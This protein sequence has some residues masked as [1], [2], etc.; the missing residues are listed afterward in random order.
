MNLQ[1]FL[2]LLIF[3]IVIFGSG[4]VF[5]RRILNENKLIYLIPLSICFGTSLFIIVLHLLSLILGVRTATN[6]SLLLF[7]FS[8]LAMFILFKPSNSIEYGISKLQFIVLCVFSS[9][10]SLLLFWYLVVFNSFDSLSHLV[11]ILSKQN[12]Y[13]S[14][15]HMCPS[16]PMAY[17][18]GV[19]LLG[20]A[21]AIFSGI[22]TW[23]SLIPIQV[24]FAF[25]VPMA[26]FASFYSLTKSFLQTMLGVLIGCF[27]ANLISLTLFTL[28]NSD[29]FNAFIHNPYRVFITM[30][31]SGFA[32]STSK[33]LVTSNM[34]VAIPF[35]LLLFFLSTNERA[36][37]KRYWFVIFIISAYLFFT[38]ESFW[39]PVLAGII[40]F[41]VIQLIQNKATLNQLKS[42]IILILFLV[43]SPLVVGGIFS[44]T[45]ITKL[46]YFD[47][48]PYTSSWSGLLLFLYPSDSNW[49]KSHEIISHTDGLR[50]YKVFFLSKYFF[51]EMG[52]P[53][54][55]LPIIFAWL[56][57]KKNTV[58]LSF[59]FS[60]IVALIIPFLI[61]YLPRP[62]EPIRF[63]TYARLV[64]S[65]LLGLFF[66]ALIQLKLQ[67][68]LSFI[69]RILLLILVFTL[70]IPP[71]TWFI[72]LKY[73]EHDYRINQVS[74]IDK[75]ALRW[76]NKHMKAGD[77]GLGP[78]NNAILFDLINLAGV[79]GVGVSPVPLFQET[80]RYT[81]FKTLDPCLLNELR[82]R[83]I[84]LNNQLL[85]LIPQE[86]LNRLTDEKVLFL[87]YQSR[88]RD[89]I[90]KIYQFK[91]INI[92]EY[93]KSKN[94]SWAIGRMYDG[95][96]IPVINASSK[97][98]I[99]FTNKES[100]L[101]FL[102]EIKKHFD[103]KEAYW[104]RTEA[105]T[106]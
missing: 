42:S 9:F 8:S 53:L 58:L 51:L 78:F 39:A 50:F 21:L 76:L 37:K 72:P 5:S 25:I 96:F 98:Q 41:Q 99:H 40:I 12:T 59:L 65:I 81:A 27:C 79:Y 7:V 83:W 43:I 15:S 77:I 20:S 67:T 92:E 95:K 63:F 68:Y 74:S 38:Y 86:T 101:R 85:S 97:S 91:P 100:A 49:Y 14:L 1:T 18:C 4:Y 60:G 22:E 104:Y 31:E 2:L 45:N 52:L 93:C 23:S 44:D 87:Q 106:N 16:A 30:S 19:I 46:V 105:I 11:T 82:V 90:R 75:K 48:K 89:N 71:I 24:I 69:I 33:A 26:I 64:F 54:I 84:Y 47:P 62:I 57:K 32:T 70:V 56:V 35:S 103:Y 66:G 80:T 36:Y 102:K 29:N 61:T 10:V 17:H 73:G 55:L 94:Y 3:F 28:F 88:D 13:P 34:A 6:I